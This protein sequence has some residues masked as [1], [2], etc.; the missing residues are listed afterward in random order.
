L[1]A[2]EGRHFV[3]TT[4]A[5]FDV[6]QITGVD[7]LSA[8]FSGSYVLAENY[9]YTVEAF[10]DYLTL[11]RP[12]G[13]LSI[14]TGDESVEAPRA[15][16]RMVSVAYEA[17][18]SIGVARPADHIAVIYGTFLD[19]ILIRTAPFEP[20]QVARLAAESERLRF[21]AVLLP[22]R[23]GQPA[24]TRLVSASAAEREGA[25]AE[26]PYVVSPTTDDQPF[27]FSFFRWRSLWSRRDLV[28]AHTSALGQAVLLALLGTLSLLSTALILGPLAVFRRRGILG[29]GRE[30]VGLLVYFLALGAGF[31]LLEISLIQ[32][33]VVFLGYP[34]YSLSV[35]LASLLVS[36]AWG[37][38]WSRRWV[39]RE[40]VALPAALAVL[41]ALIVF[42]VW[43]LPPLQ[44]RLLGASLA[45]RIATTAALLAPLGFV[46]G[47]FFPLGTRRVASIHEDLV[48]WAWGING[49]ASVTAAALAIILAMTYGFAWVWFLALLVYAAGVVALLMTERGSRSPLRAA[50]HR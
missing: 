3:R 17:L 44:H 42:Y 31:M 26:L 50:E 12:G 19:E 18:R 30:A 7:T 23:E 5:R 20:D 49:C 46:L 14:A 1:I 27:F 29:A 40:R 9:L 32:R 22:G 25:R 2:D 35:T 43:G 16:G 8:E 39:G 24:F 28:P 10:R 4:P 36:T 33:F 13:V 11:L 38:L 21:N 47:I 6:I 45:A 15:A 34:T 41:A 37:S 48:P